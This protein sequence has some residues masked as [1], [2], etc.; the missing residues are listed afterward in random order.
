MIISHQVEVCHLSHYQMFGTLRPVAVASVVSAPDSEPPVRSVREATPDARDNATSP[1]VVYQL[2][3]SPVP[4]GGYTLDVTSAGSYSQDGTINSYLWD[5]WASATPGGI[6]FSDATGTSTDVT[7][8]AAGTHSIRLTVTDDNDISRTVSIVIVLNR[9]PSVVL[10]PDTPAV[11]AD[12]LATGEWYVTAAVTDPDTVAEGATG[13]DPRDEL[14][15]AH[16]FEWT[17]DDVRGVCGRA[18]C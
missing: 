2:G 9:P 3:T 15:D 7:V 16:T 13:R 5:V 18:G 8:S 11:A 1:V 17:I 4:A 6:S 14:Y 10:T 12:V